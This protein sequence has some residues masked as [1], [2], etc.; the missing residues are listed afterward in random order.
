MSAKDLVKQ[1][2]SKDYILPKDIMEKMSEAELIELI[3]EIY[4]NYRKKLENEIEFRQRYTELVN[5]VFVTNS[6][7]EKKKKNLFDRSMINFLLSSEA[8]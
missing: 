1:I 4:K 7:K 2:E 5:Y 8:T 3:E 6:Y